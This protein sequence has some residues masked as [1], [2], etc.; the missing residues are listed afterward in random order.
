[1]IKLDQNSRKQLIETLQKRKVSI[2]GNILKII[3]T[4]GD[5][6][7]KKYIDEAIDRDKETRRK[8]LELTKKI[9]LQNYE[10]TKSKEDLEKTQIELSDSLKKT[11]ESVD[12]LV[13]SKLEAD[14]LRE[15]AEVARVEAINSKNLAEN[16]K[17]QVEND[18]DILQKRTQNELTGKI[19][20]VALW[21]V[22]GVGLLTTLLYITS[23]I[24]GKD[25]QLISSTW[26]NMMG[27]LLTNAFSI[28]GTIMGVK[29]A[30]GEKK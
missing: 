5:D 2:E 30:T 16:A 8:R 19:V 4:E 6:E 10:L 21:V 11:Q 9:Q 25:T 26:S 28:L 23:L 12:E 13:K 14:R 24:W 27:I 1:M 7:F 22:I 29:Y 20:K 15:V 17:K 18:L 3:D